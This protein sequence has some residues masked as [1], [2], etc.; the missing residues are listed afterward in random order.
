MAATAAVL[1]AAPPVGAAA[2]TQ[3]LP[4]VQTLGDL[5]P[6]DIVGARFDS[7]LGT[8]VSVAGEL[9]GTVTPDLYR[10]LGPFPQTRLTTQWSVTVP[11]DSRGA[12]RVEGLLPDQLVV[13]TVT[14]SGRYTGLPTPVALAFD[15]ADPSAFVGEA[16]PARTL[17][18]F[19]FR[20]DTPDL[21]TP[22]GGESDLTRFDGRLTHIHVRRLRIRHP[23]FGRR[24]RPRT[25]RRLGARRGVVG[26]RR[27][28]DHDGTRAPRVL[29][30]AS[31][32][33]AGS[34]RAPGRSGRRIGAADRV[35]GVVCSI[36]G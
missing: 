15:F 18:L 9:T 29:M 14:G 30:P 4:A 16:S 13:P 27:A 7:S 24:R 5:R 2:I 10:S 22:S 35:G 20:V 21:T 23:R 17:V 1:L 32:P 31:G 33:A 25:A 36:S 6:F 19:G 28:R 12:N 3:T 34:D 26:A 11:G 8:L